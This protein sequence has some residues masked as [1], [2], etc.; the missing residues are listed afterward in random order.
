M[1]KLCASER[2]QEGVPVRRRW[3]APAAPGRPGQV[4]RQLAGEALD[5]VGPRQA[6]SS[7]S[8]RRAAEVRRVESI[9]SKRSPRTGANR[10]PCADVDALLDV[11]QQ[12]IDAR[13]AHGVGVDVDGDHGAARLRRRGDA[14]DAGAG[15]EVEHTRLIR[16]SRERPRT[17][18]EQLAR[19]QQLR[20]EH[21]RQTTS[22]RQAVD[23][24]QHQR[25][26]SDA[27]GNVVRKRQASGGAA[28]QLALRDGCTVVIGASRRRSGSGRPTRRD[29]GRWPSTRASRLEHVRAAVDQVREVGRRQ[30]RAQPSTRADG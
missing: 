23:L 18:R 2:G 16:A 13:A 30:E 27:A 17:S 11:V 3:R 20:L 29:S 24:F 15:A 4:S 19:A 26:G 12:R 5:Q 14:S 7:A 10:S 28:P 9:R 8:A 22:D 1:A 25:V 6:W 21:L